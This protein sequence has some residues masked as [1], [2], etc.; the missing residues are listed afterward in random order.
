VPPRGENCGRRHDPVSSGIRCRALR[1]RSGVLRGR[2]TRSRNPRQ[3]RG[4]GRTSHSRFPSHPERASGARWQRRRSERYRRVPPPGVLA[5]AA[6]RSDGG[7]ILEEHVPFTYESIRRGRAR[8]R[9]IRSP[10][11]CR[12]GSLVPMEHATPL[13]ASNSEI[14]DALERV[15]DLIDGGG[16]EVEQGGEVSHDCHK[17]RRIC[18]SFRSQLDPSHKMFTRTG[19][20]GS[21]PRAEQRAMLTK[22]GGRQVGPVVALPVPRSTTR[23]IQRCG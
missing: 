22:C 13:R 2:M 20:D 17:G 4:C 15:A 7:E 6:G 12:R 5:S 3:T 8:D 14:A 10:G 19:M 11:A 1:G 21:R 18:K 23:A 9:R 16:A